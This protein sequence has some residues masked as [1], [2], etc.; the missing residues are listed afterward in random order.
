MVRWVRIMLGGHSSR[1]IRRN[2]RR[3]LSFTASSRLPESETCVMFPCRLR[4][5]CLVRLPWP[6]WSGVKHAP[7]LLDSLI[8]GGILGGAASNRIS[9]ASRSA[10]WLLGGSTQSSCPFD[11]PDEPLLRHFYI[12][13]ALWLASVPY[14]PC[15]SSRQG[16]WN[17]LADLRLPEQH[18]LEMI[19]AKNEPLPFVGGGSATIY[20]FLKKLFLSSTFH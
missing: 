2:R 10:D 12:S 8:V 4:Q 7:L 13:Q 14:P 9:K 20:L 17:P 6:L 5:L 16:T 1:R 18:S 15:D 19:L 3:C 11:E